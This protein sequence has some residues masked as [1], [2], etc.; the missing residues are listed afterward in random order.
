MKN[1][2]ESIKVKKFRKHLRDAIKHQAALRIAMQDLAN[3]KAMSSEKMWELVK[4]IYPETAGRHCNI[5][6]YGKKKN[7]VKIKFLDHPSQ[8]PPYFAKKDNDTSSNS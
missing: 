2:G 4:E 5:G 1:L 3:A 6:I 7:K 8:E